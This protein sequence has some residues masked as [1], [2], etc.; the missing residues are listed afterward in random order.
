M[1]ASEE[2][3]SVISGVLKD[4]ISEVLKTPKA[5]SYGLLVCEFL[6]KN[7]IRDPFLEIFRKFQST[8]KKF[9]QKFVLKIW[10]RYSVSLQ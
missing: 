4:V 2:K 6:I 5:E 3:K 7:P 8:F 10:K 1:S 9:G